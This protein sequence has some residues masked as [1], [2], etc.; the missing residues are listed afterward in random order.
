M[1][2]EYSEK[3]LKRL[4]KVALTFVAVALVCVLL[5]L[6]DVAWVRSIGLVVLTGLA[7]GLTGAG[8]G[9]LFGIPRVLT[10]EGA[11]A[12]KTPAEVAD[13]ASAESDES[14]GDQGRRLLG[15]NSNLE[16]V[17]DWLTK[18]IVGLSLVEFHRLNDALVSFRLF[19]GDF[20]PPSDALTP[21]VAC[22]TL[23]F[24]AVVGFL[25]MYLET[26]LVLSRIFGSVEQ[27]LSRMLDRARK[28][29]KQSAVLTNNLVAATRAA[30]EGS[31]ENAADSL[32]AAA[33]SGQ[34]TPGLKTLAAEALARTG[35]TE[36][37]HEMLASGGGDAAAKISQMLIALYED[38]PRG[39]ERVL[40]IAAELN[41]VPVAR[42]RADF[43]FYQAAAWG[44]K[45]QY[46][47][48]QEGSEQELG[49]A[50]DN[51]LD[52]ARRSVAADPKYGDR[53]ARLIY[54]ARSSK[55]DDL[56]DFASDPEF[57]V[58]V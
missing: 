2:G 21:L 9:F 24:A 3:H 48:S 23:I 16:Q 39:Y 29:E 38:K 30:Q 45:H 43:W 57:E 26:R 5:A 32:K 15:S 6:V 42:E 36:E 22:V 52:C 27:E 14:S 46:L 31:L 50:R 40:Q 11:P 8:M 33:T 13:A 41:A 1:D 34:A 44:Q 17:S 18:I 25:W 4:A 37:A 19:V 10:S 54:P 49:S 58:F 53:I 28:R 7:A 12:A 55:D 47:R 56:I 20:V 35:R 51:A